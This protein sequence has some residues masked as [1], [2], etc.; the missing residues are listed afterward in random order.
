MQDKIFK[1]KNFEA[2]QKSLKSAKFFSLEIFRQL[3]QL[4]IKLPT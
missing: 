1:V 4:Y 3:A 2:I